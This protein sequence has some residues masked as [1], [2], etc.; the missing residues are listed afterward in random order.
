M[1]SEPT[2]RVYLREWLT[3]YTAG[4]MG[5]VGEQECLEHFAAKYAGRVRD[6]DRKVVSAAPDWW[7]VLKLNLWNLKGEYRDR[8]PAAD[9]LQAMGS[10]GHLVRR[11]SDEEKELLAYGKKMLPDAG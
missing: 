9:L 2:W 5:D 4:Y 8:N 6:E 3:V 7:P 1:N 11:G 10:N